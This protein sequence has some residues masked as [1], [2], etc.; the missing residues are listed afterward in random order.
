VATV[1]QTMR[2]AI[3]MKAGATSLKWFIEILSNESHAESLL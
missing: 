1:D 3:S 2:W